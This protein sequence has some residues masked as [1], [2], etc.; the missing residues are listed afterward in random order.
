MSDDRTM[1]G[2]TQ[3]LSPRRL[4]AADVDRASFA[5]A[6]L[7]GISEPEVRAFLDRVR[8]ELAVLAD[9]R[10][11][12][13]AQ[14]QRLQDATVAGKQ[15]TGSPGPADVHGVSVL[16]TA[17]RTADKLRADADAEAARTTQTAKR[18]R[19]QLLADAEEKAAALLR[20]AE[21]EAAT[22]RAQAPAEA[23]VKLARWQTMGSGLTGQLSALGEAVAA[24]LEFW[25]E[26]PGAEPE[27]Q[28]ERPARRSRAKQAPLS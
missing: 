25:G 10:D 12:A 24:T 2:L 6:R 9:E 27:S 15:D 26:Q 20:D 5:K 11:N 4:T 1:T 16:Q 7:G 22:V 17:Q 8:D 21:Q 23:R 3:L 19:D 14:L 28:P 13:L 18:Q